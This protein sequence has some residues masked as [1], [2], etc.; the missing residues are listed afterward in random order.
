MHNVGCHSPPQDSEQPFA[1]RRRS[2]VGRS[3]QLRRTEAQEVTMDKVTTDKNAVISCHGILLSVTSLV[4][5]ISPDVAAAEAR[6]S[7]SYGQLP[8]HFEANR[9]QAPEDIAFLTRGS[10]YSLY[11]AAT[12]A[13]LVLDRPNAPEAQRGRNSRDLDD[14]PATAAPP[15]VLSMSLVGAAPDPHASGIEQQPGKVNYFIGN[16]PARWRAD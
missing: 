1:P 13:V 15:V 4:G 3:G 11:L 9:G 8:M 5:S 7:D 14:A 16:D 2:L 6:I 10:G 12:E